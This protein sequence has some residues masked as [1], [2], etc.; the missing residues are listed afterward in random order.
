M[1]SG[2]LA[3]RGPIRLGALQFAYAA[4][5]VFVVVPFAVWLIIGDHLYAQYFLEVKAPPLRQ[6]FGFSVDRVRIGSPPDA[7]EVHAISRL[8][9]GGVLARAGFRFGDVPTGYLDA[10]RAA[11]YQELQAVLDGHVV[12]FRLTTVK[13]LQAG[14]GEQRSVTLGPLAL[15]GAEG[16]TASSNRG[17]AQQ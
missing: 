10:G 16:D 17:A 4:L 14:E 6:R 7:Y 2:A 11:F 12:T 15:S 1:T 13:S 5:F 9:P 3:A 8:T